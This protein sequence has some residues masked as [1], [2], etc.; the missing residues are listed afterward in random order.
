MKKKWV[1]YAFFAIFLGLH[2][3]VKV[4]AT[5]LKTQER[6]LEP[7]V[8]SDFEVSHIGE[9]PGKIGITGEQQA[10]YEL[11]IEITDTG[12]LS[13]SMFIYSADGGVTWSEKILIPLSGYYALGST[14]LI[15]N[16]F[17]PVT[18]DAFFLQGDRYEC[19]IPD[20]RTNIV[21]EQEGNSEAEILIISNHS[22][23]RAFNVL[24]EMGN[25]IQV[26]I[27]K[28]GSFGTAVWQISKDGGITW[29]E[30]AYAEKS[31]VIRSDTDK[32]LC[33]TLKFTTESSNGVLF[34]KD[35]VYT[36]YAERKTDNSAI[37]AITII[38]VLVG[39]VGAVFYCGN[40]KLKAAIP[41][42]LDY[43]IKK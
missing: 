12:L 1:Y 19:Y 10:E 38:A 11:Q 41:S 14:G 5:D 9:G 42:E 15:I 40:K 18:K 24:E 20:P 16:F 8:Q 28:S 13:Q 21:V 27:L 4:Y 17:L 7:E 39:V 3:P 37:T 33:L 26:K 2:A 22:E 25:K 6:D 30:Q 32:T 36:I 35:D 34:E 23:K 29:S 43:E 31:V